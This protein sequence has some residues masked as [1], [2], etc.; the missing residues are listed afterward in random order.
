[1]TNITTIIE[2]L[3][4][5]QEIYGDRYDEKIKE[6]VLLKNTGQTERINQN[7]CDR[8][9]ILGRITGIA[10]ALDMLKD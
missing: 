10:D 4:I 5:L 2:K 7:D 6:F 8:S 9:F 3:E 1:M